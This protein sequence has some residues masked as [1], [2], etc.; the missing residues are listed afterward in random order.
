MA[1]KTIA[2]ENMNGTRKSQ[3]LPRLSTKPSLLR[4]KEDIRQIV[5]TALFFATFIL[6]WQSFA[7]PFHG[8]ILSF[9]AWLALFQLSFMGAVATHNVIH[10]P[11]FYDNGWNSLYQICL[12]LQY[13][14]PVSV[15]VPGHNLSHHKY[16]QQ[17]RDFSEC[18]YSIS[19]K[20]CQATPPKL[21][22]S[23]THEER[24]LSPKVPRR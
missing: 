13:G 24:K 20:S 2:L 22:P 23:N 12:S 4:H 10:L 11:V 5:C 8:G 16:P 1:S 3:L 7:S 6:S 15:F 19:S 9:A 21:P 18:L 14:G 17:A